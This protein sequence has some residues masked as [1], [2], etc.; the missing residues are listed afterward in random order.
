MMRRRLLSILALCSLA[1][2]LTAFGKSS[3]TFS[4]LIPLASITDGVDPIPQIELTTAIAGVAPIGNFT[5]QTEL[6]TASGSA[7][8]TLQ[9]VQFVADSDPAGGTSA[10]VQGVIDEPD[11]IGIAL[12]VAI[13]V[14]DPNPIGVTVSA[15]ITDGVDPIPQ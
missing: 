7:P 10:V 5:I 14:D 11:P 6:V 3:Q 12:R 9:V 2:P 1:L 8:A 15:G 4:F 13:V